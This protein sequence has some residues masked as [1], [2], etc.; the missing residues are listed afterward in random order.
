LFF[1]KTNNPSKPIFFSQVMTTTTTTTT[2]IYNKQAT[3]FASGVVV[4]IILLFL[5]LVLPAQT[6]APLE[7]VTECINVPDVF[8]NP[9]GLFYTIPSNDI[10]LF[11]KINAYAIYL[12]NKGT[13][14]IVLGFRETTRD[15]QTR[16]DSYYSE[17]YLTACFR[18]QTPCYLPNTEV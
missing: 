18:E 12:C 7:T 17:L 15:F 16:P 3:I 14:T 13:K 8:L 1:F 4:S 10:Y 6:N 5:S 9:R 11:D 2:R